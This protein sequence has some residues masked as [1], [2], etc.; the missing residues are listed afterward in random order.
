MSSPEEQKAGEEIAEDLLDAQTIF[1]YNMIK[2]QN[3]HVNIITELYFT[4][5]LAYLLDDPDQFSKDIS[6]DQVPTFASGE[7]YLATLMDSLI[8][9][10]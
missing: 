9:Q 10:A 4:E 3:P 1:K 8:C 6:Y 5:N 7:V 2:K